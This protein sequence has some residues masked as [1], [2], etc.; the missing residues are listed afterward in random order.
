[1]WKDEG[2]LLD[3]FNEAKKLVR[4]FQGVSRQDFFRDEERQY[5]AFWSISVMGEAAGKVSQKFRAENPDLPWR[6]M[7][8]IRNV[9]IHN[10]ARIDLDIV[11][12]V[13]THSAP[14]LI[15]SIG[16]LLPDKDEV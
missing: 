15:Q 9:L 12:G 1:M 5:V 3:I 10:Y 7:I 6:E 16:P 13:I 8:G 2:Y 11:W 14:Q 4:H